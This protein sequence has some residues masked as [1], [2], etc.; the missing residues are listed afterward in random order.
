MPSPAVAFRLRMSVGLSPH[1]TLLKHR[2]RSSSFRTPQH[3]APCTRRGRL[4]RGPGRGH[5]PPACTGSTYIRTAPCSPAALA[6]DGKPWSCPYGRNSLSLPASFSGTRRAARHSFQVQRLPYLFFFES[7]DDL[8]ADQKHREG[9]AG[10]GFLD[11]LD[12][13]A[14]LVV[15]ELI[16][17]YTI[18]I[19]TAFIQKVLCIFAVYAGS[20]S[21][22][23]YVRVFHLGPPIDRSEEKSFGGGVPGF[24]PG[25]VRAKS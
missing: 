7:D 13:P 17:V 20:E 8:G 22:K 23:L 1:S 2:V 18:V 19:D 24:M 4:Y 6:G 16:D 5:R 11:F 14:P 12:H 3:R 9:T 25:R 15:I 10:V 21:V